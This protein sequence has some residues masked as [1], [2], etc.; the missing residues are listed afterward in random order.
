MIFQG[1]LI[2]LVS[3][4]SFRL[5]FQLRRKRITLMA[6]LLWMVLWGGAVVI[7]IWPNITSEI[8]QSVGIGRGVDLVIYLSVISL[9]Y[10]IFRLYSKIYVLQ[11]DITT[12]IIKNA[13][14]NSEFTKNAKNK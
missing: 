10:L 11:K 8:A 7:T 4:I 6:F 2:A 9:F 14:H 1:I 13:Q 5:L 3:L 12:L